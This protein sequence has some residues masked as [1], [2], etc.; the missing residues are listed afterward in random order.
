MPHCDDNY[1]A[2]VPCPPT[3]QTQS[4]YL[5]FSSVPK[6]YD[7]PFFDPQTAVHA[8]V[9]LL[10][11]LSLVLAAEV[12]RLATTATWAAAH[13]WT[14]SALSCHTVSFASC[15]PSL[16][17]ICWYS[18]QWQ[19]WTDPLSLHQLVVVANTHTKLPFV[20]VSTDSR[21]SRKDCN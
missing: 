17:W 1:Q 2:Q 6:Q 10:C 19:H 16:I 11:Q 9:S 13:L 7:L 18:K 4:L 5:L 8:Q 12:A 3:D 20:S 21:L 15:L 14:A